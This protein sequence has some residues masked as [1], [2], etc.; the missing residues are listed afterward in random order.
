MSDSG[1][2][3]V[4]GRRRDG[5]RNGVSSVSNGMSWRSREHV[6]DKFA[7]EMTPEPKHKPHKVIRY[8]VCFVGHVG[9]ESL[10][11]PE[12]KVRGQTFYCSPVLTAK[13]HELL[14][15]PEHSD[16]VHVGKKIGVHHILRT[17]KAIDSERPS[18]HTSF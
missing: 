5:V 14:D 13:C 15:V 16:T 1:A 10:G 9:I 12:G 4:A 11:S 7:A 17:Q 6:A 2:V 3:I 8:R 18:G